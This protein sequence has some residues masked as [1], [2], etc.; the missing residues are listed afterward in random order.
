MVTTLFKE[1][2][3]LLLNLKWR[4]RLNPGNMEFS[5]KL[6]EV[7]IGCFFRTGTNLD[8]IINP[9]G[10]GCSNK[11]C[12]EYGLPGVSRNLDSNVQIVRNDFNLDT[13]H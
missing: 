9:R 10:E 2:G 5:S 4:A 11:P 6:I 1:D 7:M 3:S 12:S 8:V 13:F